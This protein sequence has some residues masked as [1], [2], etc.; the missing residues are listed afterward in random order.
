MPKRAKKTDSMAPMAS[1]PQITHADIAN[2]AKLIEELST[3][4]TAEFRTSFSSLEAKLS[5]IHATL[6]DRGQH[7]TSLEDGADTCSDRVEELEA[8]VT[9]MIVREAQTY[10]VKP[11]PISEN[12]PQDVVSA[13]HLQDPRPP[14]LYPS[15]LFITTKD[16]KKHL[17]SPK[18]AA[19]TL[20]EFQTDEEPLVPPPERDKR[21]YSRLCSRN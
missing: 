7:L 10:R 20:T 9:E 15:R 6:S 5:N 17:K 21:R 3:T 12:Y 18:E 1:T 2:I 11:V 16:E 19:D 14:L 13:L 8:G 4:L